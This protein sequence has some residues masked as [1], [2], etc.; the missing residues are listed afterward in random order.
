LTDS[1]TLKIEW[2]IDEDPKGND[3]LPIII[4]ICGNSGSFYSNKG[5][6]NLRTRP[7]LSLGNF[8]KK[9]FPVILQKRLEAF[10]IDFE[11]VDLLES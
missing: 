8:D 1:K 6:Q 2:F 9:I 10:P 7:K 11:G 5:D 4:K 3:H